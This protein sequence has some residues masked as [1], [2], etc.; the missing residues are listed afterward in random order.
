[1]IHRTS[2]YEEVAWHNAQLLADKVHEA[3]DRADW[4]RTA[5]ILTII[6]FVVIS[7][8]ASG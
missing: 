7:I 2:K 1:M 3:N 8:A 6:E 4:W 5:W